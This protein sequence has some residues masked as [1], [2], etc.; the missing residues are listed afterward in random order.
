MEYVDV[1]KI[2]YPFYIQSRIFGCNLFHLPESSK[3][4]KVSIKTS[5]ILLIIIHLGIYIWLF[6]TLNYSTTEHDRVLHNLLFHLNK[7]SGSVITEFLSSIL[8]HIA[9]VTNLFTTTM[10]LMNR[11]KIWK[12]LSEIRNFDMKV[13]ICISLKAT[14]PKNI[15][16][17]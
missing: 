6:V 5:D 17:I 7:K 1:V 14:R 8:F 12:I 16:F 11:N 4:I 9:G 13:R 10:D 15:F 3:T 2:F